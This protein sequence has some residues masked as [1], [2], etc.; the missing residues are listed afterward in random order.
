MSDMLCDV[1]RLGLD[2]GPILG[3]QGRDQAGP[4]V[5]G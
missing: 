5:G 3:T 1:G 4:G 2:L